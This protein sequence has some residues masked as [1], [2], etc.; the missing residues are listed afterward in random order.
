MF[1][2]DT[3]RS[4]VAKGEIGEL[5]PNA[6]TLM[7]GIYSTRQ[8]TEQLVPA[9]VERCLEDRLDAVLLVAV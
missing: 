8:V 6:Y 3:L 5:G 2:I 4:L 7:G 9:L 1:P